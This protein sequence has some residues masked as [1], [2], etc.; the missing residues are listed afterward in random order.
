V[1]EDRLVKQSP[2]Q[3]KRGNG[4]SAFSAVL[5]GSL[6][7]VLS[8]CLSVAPTDSQAGRSPRCQIRLVPGCSMLTLQTRA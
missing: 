1:A 5:H 6:H 2:T 8:P 3:Q 7:G 4:R